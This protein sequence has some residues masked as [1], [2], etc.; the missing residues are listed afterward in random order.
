MVPRQ[1]DDGVGGAR[2]L[3]VEGWFEWYGWVGMAPYQVDDGVVG[4]VARDQLP[5]PSRKRVVHQVA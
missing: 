2:A 5:H 4:E 1:V 3:G